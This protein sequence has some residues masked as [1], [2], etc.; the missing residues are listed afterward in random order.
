LQ[1]CGTVGITRISGRANQIVFS[2]FV[3]TFNIHGCILKIQGIGTLRG[4]SVHANNNDVECV[5]VSK[6]LIE[7]YKQIFQFESLKRQ[8]DKNEI[9]LRH[10]NN[11]KS[12]KDKKQENPEEIIKKKEN[13]LK[14]IDELYQ[15]N[16]K[17]ID[18]IKYLNNSLIISDKEAKLKCISV[19]ANANNS[20]KIERKAY[21]DF[22][23]INYDIFS[24]LIKQN[25]AANYFLFADYFIS[26]NQILIFI[27][28]FGDVSQNVICEVG[29][30]DNEQSI[31]I[32]YF[33]DNKEISDSEIFKNK[34]I[35]NGISNIV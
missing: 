10:I 14:I 30:Y 18:N 22:E 35:D 31:N 12:F 7:K 1:L 33:L 2:R 25:I 28:D 5:I 27:K 21:I 16:K 34:L 11:I 9:I 15:K 3:A 20:N 4:Q 19:Y 29:K 8:L 32:E 24:L 13:I 26:S 6:I 23:I 17:L